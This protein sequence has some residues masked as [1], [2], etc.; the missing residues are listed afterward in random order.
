MT[1]PIPEPEDDAAAVEAPEATPLL[2]PV[3][4]RMPIILPRAA[5][6]QWLDPELSDPLRLL[7]RIQP[8]PAERIHL[9]PVST[10]VNNTAHDGPAL[11]APLPA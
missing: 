11:I 3:H 1:G 10:E 7:E 8:P 4:A 6:A 2:A 5:E 9:Y